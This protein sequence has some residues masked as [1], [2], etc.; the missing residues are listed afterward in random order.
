MACLGRKRHCVIESPGAASD[1]GQYRLACL[2]LQARRRMTDKAVQEPIQMRLIVE[3]KLM[4]Y[5]ANWITLS[6][7]H[8]G[9]ACAIDLMQR[10]LREASYREKTALQ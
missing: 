7:Q 10:G 8:R 5:I 2:R 3:A 4:G 9:R 1:N 6:Q